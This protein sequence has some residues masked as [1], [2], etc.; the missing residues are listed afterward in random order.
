HGEGAEAKS[1]PAKT[2]MML[3]SGDRLRT[4]GGGHAVIT[5]FTGAT[6]TLGPDTEVRIASLLQGPTGAVEASTVVALQQSSGVTWSSVPKLATTSSRYQID[7]PAGQ[8][9]AR[10]TAFQ[11]RLDGSG[12]SEVQAVE[13]SVLVRGQGA[14]VTLPPLTQSTLEAGKTPTQPAPLSGFSETV[15]FTVGAGVWP[16]I[17]DEAG[18]TAGMIAPGIVVN[19]IPGATV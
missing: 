12:R 19:Q 3:N 18:R 10:G 4:N 9:Q 16:R 15:R 2:G 17:V 7:T 13:G 5:F 8:A 6:I 11:V 14:D 1:E